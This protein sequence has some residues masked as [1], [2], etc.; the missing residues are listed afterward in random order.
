MLP[1]AARP[2]SAAAA[3][4][5]GHAEQGPVCGFLTDYATLLPLLVGLAI[6]WA[7]WAAIAAGSGWLFACGASAGWAVLASAW[8]HRR[9]WAAGTVQAIA[10]VAP[11]VVAGMSAAAGWMSPAGLVLAAPLTS[12]LVAALGVLAGPRPPGRPERDQA[13]AVPSV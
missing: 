5:S 13:D 4:A 10:W 12:V 3:P 7:G 8:L 1:V 2:G 9:G 11:A 6:L